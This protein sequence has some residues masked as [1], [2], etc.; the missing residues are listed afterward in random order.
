MKNFIGN[1]IACIYFI[2]IILPFS[3]ILWFIPIG[4]FMD[5][6]SITKSGFSGQ[7][8]GLAFLG[9]FGFIFGISMVVPALRRIYKK[10]PWLYV[11][12]QVFM[13]DILILTVATYLLNIGFEVQNTTRHLVF[14]WMMI[15]T[16]I[17]SRLAM[18]VYYKFKPLKIVKE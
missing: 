2:T 4:M 8:S 5:I 16:L 17:I 9:A 10:L 14:F 18:C 3:L 13:I 15:A 1:V 6:N 11:Y 12:I 7:N